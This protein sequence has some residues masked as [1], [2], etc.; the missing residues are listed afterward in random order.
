MNDAPSRW[1][2]C[3][4]SLGELNSDDYQWMCMGGCGCAVTRD[5][6]AAAQGPGTSDPRTNL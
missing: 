1:M 5:W 6:W 4:D 2:L 3:G